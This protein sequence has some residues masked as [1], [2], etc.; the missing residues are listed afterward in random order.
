VLAT[1]KPRH[2]HQ[3]FLS[4]RREIDKAVPA[5]LDVRCI[6][7]NYGRRKHPKVWAWLAAKPLW[8]MDFMPTYSSWLNQVERLLAL[9]TDK[10][11]RWGSF[12]S[13][14]RL[15]KGFDQFVSHY[16]ENCKPFMWTASADSIL[17]TLH[18]LC[19]RISGTE[20]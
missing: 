5:E 8:H 12:G 11:I 17:G 14:K 6:V 16:N 7:D 13:V 20:H 9:I 3:E 19:S 4:F 1:C 15:I 10:A 18:R 2:R